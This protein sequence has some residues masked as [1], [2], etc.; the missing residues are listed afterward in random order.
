MKYMEFGRVALHVLVWEV[1]LG[2]LMGSEVGS[3]S[4]VPTTASHR[5]AGIGGCGIPEPNAEAT[6]YAK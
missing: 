3:E 1:W 4:P 6:V 2:T 5:T